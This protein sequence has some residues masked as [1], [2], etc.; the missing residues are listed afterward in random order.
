MCKPNPSQLT[1]THQS[2]W[3]LMTGMAHIPLANDGT[4]LIQMSLVMKVHGDSTTIDPG[5][6]LKFIHRFFIT[7]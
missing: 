6:A 1:A 5:G 7:A 3:S 2:G 4:S